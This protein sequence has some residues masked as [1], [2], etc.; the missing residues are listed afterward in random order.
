MFDFKKNLL[1]LFFPIFCLG[2]GKEGEWLC[3][4]CLTKIEI[5]FGKQ[6]LTLKNLTGVWVAADYRQPLLAKALQTFKYN[7]ILELGENL[8]ELL[9][10]FLANQLKQNP[11]CSFDLVVPVPLAKKRKLWRSFN[12]AEIL[13]K[14]VSQKFNWP[15]GLNL[16]SRKYHTHPQVNLKAAERL[17]NV[18]GIFV[19]KSHGLE[20]KKILLIDDVVTT[21]A[22]LQECAKVLKQ[23]GAKE[24]WG[25]VLAKG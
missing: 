6:P 25:L 3:P 16:I 11:S 14:K 8:G 9:I 13:A 18:Q 23:A 7:F 20:D 4:N 2:C 21:G 10:E 22:T 5:N 24:I 15:L 19:A 17:I 12:Q 1:D